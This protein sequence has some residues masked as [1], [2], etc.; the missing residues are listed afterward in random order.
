MNAHSKMTKQLS[1]GF[2]MWSLLLVI[3]IFGSSTLQT[4]KDTGELILKIK[5]LEK[6]NTEMLM[7]LEETQESL[8]TLQETVSLGEEHRALL[9]SR[10]G[11][12][13]KAPTRGGDPRKVPVIGPT[14]KVETSVSYTMNA[15]A[16][17]AT[18]L[19]GG[20][21]TGLTAMGKEPVGGQTVAVD[22]KLIPLGTKLQLT[23][24][25]YPSVN[26]I[27]IA[28]DKGGAIKGK[29]IDIYFDDWNRDPHVARKEMLAFGRRT[30]VVTIIN[31]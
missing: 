31:D 25:S 19:N 24:D 26:G 20:A 11:E 23:C 5:E 4:Y 29:K 2:Y 8:S 27:Y 1:S 21:G 18:K 30:V 13:D 22:P 10:L 9:D 6:S 7:G 16:Y 28:E 14:P 3:F 17:G 15:S 12:L